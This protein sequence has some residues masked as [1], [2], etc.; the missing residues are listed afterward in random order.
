RN[1]SEYYKEETTAVLGGLAYFSEKKSA[2]GYQN[3]G[4]FG[5]PLIGGLLWNYEYEEETGFEKTSVLKFV[6]SRTAYK[7]KVTN[8]ILGINWGAL[9][10]EK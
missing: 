2:R 3:H 5:F 8:R 1:R 10:S 4:V 7:G 9:F 6:Y